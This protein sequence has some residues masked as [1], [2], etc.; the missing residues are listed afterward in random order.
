[1]NGILS[2][3]KSGLGTGQ[4]L[5]RE[6]SSHVTTYFRTFVRS[7]ENMLCRGSNIGVKVIGRYPD[8][9]LIGCGNLAIHSLSQTESCF[10]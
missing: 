7:F 6:C 8:H 5:S 3:A 2:S 1:M 9:Y 10:V 4:L